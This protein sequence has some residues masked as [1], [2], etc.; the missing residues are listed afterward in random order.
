MIQGW[1][2]RV[3]TAACSGR[4][5]FG[6]IESFVVVGSLDP[7]FLGTVDVFT[8]SERHGSCPNGNGAADVYEGE[9]PCTML[10]LLNFLVRFA[11]FVPIDI[12]FSKSNFAILVG[13]L[14]SIK[15]SQFSQYPPKLVKMKFCQRSVG[16]QIGCGLWKLRTSVNES[17]LMLPASWGC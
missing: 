13:F 4:S 17:P 7:R 12:F 5:D 16:Y 6:E 11:R 2:C 9:L 8:I 1:G 10:L 14:E 15:I 3:E